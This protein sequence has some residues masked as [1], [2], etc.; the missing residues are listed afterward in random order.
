M[1]RWG[2]TYFR[3]KFLDHLDLDYLEFKQALLKVLIIFKI[4]LSLLS[5]ILG[6][7]ILYFVNDQNRLE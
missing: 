5:K 3:N 7:V 1:L 4:Y 6:F 2:Y